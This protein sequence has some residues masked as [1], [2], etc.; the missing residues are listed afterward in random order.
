MDYADSKDI[1]D[2]IFTVFLLSIFVTLSIYFI[3]KI[4]EAI[5]QSKEGK[6]ERKDYSREED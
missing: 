6:L 5:K 4:I 2:R 1:L 3:I